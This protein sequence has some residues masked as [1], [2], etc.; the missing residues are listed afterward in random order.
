MSK[1]GDLKPRFDA[2]R[3]RSPPILLMLIFADDPASDV[4][5]GSSWKDVAPG[6]WK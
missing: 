2:K 3:V 6:R 4:A 5:S 1:P